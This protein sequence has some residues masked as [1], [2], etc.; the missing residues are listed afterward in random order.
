M[1]EDVNQLLILIS[2]RIR[3]EICP[4]KDDL[5]D[6]DAESRYNGSLLSKYS[7]LCSYGSQ[8][9]VTSKSWKLGYQR[10]AVDKE[11]VIAE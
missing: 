5:F 4:S 1:Y 8:L 9:C 2:A 11:R 6:S 3:Q 10:G 7:P